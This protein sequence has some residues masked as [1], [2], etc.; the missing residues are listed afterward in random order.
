MDLEESLRILA[1]PQKVSGGVK[2]MERRQKSVVFKELFPF[3]KAEEEKS[4]KALSHIGV[5]KVILNL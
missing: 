4:S 1:R 2:T 3:F 5:G